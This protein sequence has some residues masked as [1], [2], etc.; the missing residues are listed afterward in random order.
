MK[1]SIEHAAIL[2]Q[3]S[4]TLIKKRNYKEAHE[5]NTEA[6]LIVKDAKEPRFPHFRP[7]TNSW[8]QGYHF[9]NSANI[10]LAN[11]EYVSAESDFKTALK[12]FE[13]LQLTEYGIKIEV[14]RDYSALLRTLVRPEE[15]DQMEHQIKQLK[16][17]VRL[18][19]SR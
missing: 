19:M 16:I 10:K 8:C 14:Y 1:K 3:I 2:L 4:H 15:A 9:F 11:K 17:K 12:Y 7:P 5:L 18:A 6:I 13:S